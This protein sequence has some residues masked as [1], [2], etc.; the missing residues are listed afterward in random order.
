[1]SIKRLPFFL[2]AAKHLSFTEAANEHFISQTAISLQIKK[3]E[4]ELGFQLFT[5]SNTGVSLTPAGSYLY[6]RCQYV[7]A[8]YN[9][10][11]THARQ[12]SVDA[13]PKIKIGYSG[14]YEQNSVTPLVEKFY[15]NYPS[16]QV[17]LI[18]GKSKK[19]VLHQLEEGD[20]DLAVISAF[21]RN[22]NQWLKSRIISRDSCLF[23]LSADSKFAQCEHLAPERLVGVPMLITN[24]NDFASDEWQ[25]QNILISMGLGDNEVIYT[26][27][28]Y[29][30]ALIVKAGI[31]FSI[32][33]E[34][35][36]EMPTE[37]I[38]LVEIADRRLRTSCS[39]VYLESNVNP[40]V[41]EFLSLIE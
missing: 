18:Y 11:I 23:L 4:E 32:V 26:N 2:S 41:E 13:K 17:E 28:F 39:V 7:M 10:A 25:V 40:M 6:K 15:V 5:R 38:A 9:R 36:R 19:S 29:S 30:L 35:M 21:D 14:A 20:I 12:I 31:G 27:D 3:Y 33:P 34:C 1:M 24:E 37:G 16:T 8:E 22:Y